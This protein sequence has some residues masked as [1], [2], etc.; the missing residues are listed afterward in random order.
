[1]KITL[2]SIFYLL[3]LIGFFVVSAFVLFFAGYYDE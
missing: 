3:G 2:F 1:M